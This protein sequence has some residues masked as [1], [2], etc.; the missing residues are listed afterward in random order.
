MANSEDVIVPA[1]LED[2]VAGSASALRVSPWCAP[3]LWSAVKV[4]L[5]V[6]L[7]HTFSTALSLLKSHLCCHSW[8]PASPISWRDYFVRVV[9]TAVAT[10]LDIA[11]SSFSLALV[12]R[13]FYSMWRVVLPVVGETEFELLGFIFV[14]L[15]SFMAGLRWVLLQVLLQPQLHSACVLC[16]LSHTP[17]SSGFSPF[18]AYLLWS[19]HPHAT[20]S[21]PVLLVPLASH[22]P[23]V[24]PPSTPTGLT[25][26][27]L[28]LLQYLAP[29]MALVC[30]IFS[31]LHE[32]WSSLA[33]LPY[34]DTWPH[35]L[36]TLAVMPVGGILAFC[37]VGCRA[38]R[39][40]SL[41]AIGCTRSV[42]SSSL[43]T[44]GQALGPTLA[45][46]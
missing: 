37:M 13:T 45:A 15:A 34:F 42:M 43:T 22:Q 44:R 1:D 36:W 12:T 31:L 41:K 20:I 2:D 7:W 27:L 11:L 38:T 30:G 6:L 33:S 16:L 35:A 46:F 14:M 29:V 9:P 19:R 8:L 28:T 10:S 21:F 3:W 32:P 17:Q 26:P 4:V 24:R 25:N 40:M 18:L 5:L 23:Q 39:H